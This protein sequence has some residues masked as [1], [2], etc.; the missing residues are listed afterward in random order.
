VGSNKE[1]GVNTATGFVALENNI[2][3]SNNT[4]VATA[5]DYNSISLTAMKRKT[6]AIRILGGKLLKV[7][8]L[9]Y[10]AQSFHKAAK[11]LARSLQLD[12]NS[13]S[14]VDF[15][16]VVN[17]YRLALELHLKAL[18]L[19]DGGNFLKTKPDAMSVH[20]THSVS[21]LAQLVTQIVTA[22]GWQKEFRC[23]GVE[24]LDDFK[25]VVESVN[26]V[27][28]GGY[29]YR[30]F[31]DDQMEFDVEGFCRKMDALL[32]LLDSTADGLA[33]EW[34]LRSGAVPELEPDDGDECFGQT[35]Q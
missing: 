22:V 14:D 1:G 16:P 2:S 20:K 29:T 5:S 35:I 6:P 3:G 11:T 26:S 7:G 33:A 32:V 17:M 24:S 23:L 15:S 27:D 12:G 25:A 21:W 8:D 28:P 4:A 10:Y 18:V 9:P 19:G 31:V 30:C 34:D 13:P